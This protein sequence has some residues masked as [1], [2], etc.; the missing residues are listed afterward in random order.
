MLNFTGKGATNLKK[1]GSINYHKIN[2]SK[3]LFTKPVVATHDN[4]DSST[5]EKKI[6]S[7]EDFR[8]VCNNNLQLIRKIEEIISTIRSLNKKNNYSEYSKRMFL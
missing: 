7:K 4:N 3:L 8:K 1:R 2:K 6:E 5:I